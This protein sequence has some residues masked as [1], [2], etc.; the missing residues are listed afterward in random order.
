MFAQEAFVG[1]GGAR[2][3]RVA[4]TTRLQSRCRCCNNWI[5]LYVI[6]PRGPLCFK[7]YRR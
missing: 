5:R 2:W 3:A 1:R 4:D 7:N 6:K